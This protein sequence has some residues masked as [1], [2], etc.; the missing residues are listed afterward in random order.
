MQKINLEELGYVRHVEV[1]FVIAQILCLGLLYVLY[2]K[3]NAL[4]DNGTKIKIPEVKQLGQVVAPEK[5]QTPKEYDMTA[6]GEQL[7]QAVMGAVIL[8]GV[9]YKWRYVMPLV[10]QVFMTPIKLYESPL[11]QMHMMGKS[12]ARP[13]PAP[14]PF[15]FPTT[16]AAEPAEPAT[17]TTASEAQDSSTPAKKKQ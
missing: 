9:Y 4:E 16:P 15:G 2:S 8:G 10:L 14:N 3:I 11:F 6:W 13:F 7:K 17:V 12:Q 1:A 5:M